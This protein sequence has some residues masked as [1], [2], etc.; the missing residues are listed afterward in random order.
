MS[1]ELL[2]L[3]GKPILKRQEEQELFKQRDQLRDIMIKLELLDVKSKKRNSINKKIISIQNII[4]EANQRLLYSM[5]KQFA[6]DFISIDELVC[7]G[8]LTL[9]RSVE[10][11]DVSR[12]YCFSTYATNALRNFFSRQIQR[13]SRRQKKIIPLTGQTVQGI[14]ADQIDNR[15]QERY[16]YVTLLLR[17]LPSREKTIIEARFGLGHFDQ[18]HTFR[19]IANIVGLSKE[20]VRVLAHHSISVLAE[21]V[22]CLDVSLV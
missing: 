15:Q 14:P 18:P 20:R 1:C 12:G 11:F 13:E 17:H 5:S 8:E 21:H 6:R 2:S 4:V 16:H 7:M 19:Q 22:S 10:L 3:T 9:M